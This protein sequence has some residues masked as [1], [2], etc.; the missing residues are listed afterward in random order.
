MGEWFKGGKWTPAPGS[1]PNGAGEE[2]V[3]LVDPSPVFWR[4]LYFPRVVSCITITARGATGRLCGIHVTQATEP[5]KAQRL[6]DRLKE[7]MD[8]VQ[9]TAIYVVGGLWLLGSGRASGWLGTFRS[10]GDL[11]DA[12]VTSLGASGAA[13]HC[14]GHPEGAQMDYLAA[15]GYG[16]VVWFHSPAGRGVWTKFHP[17]PCPSG[18]RRR[19]FR[20]RF[21]S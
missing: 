4:E 20:G 3:G 5:V 21:R 19:W 12:V 10:A 13:R 6:L 7:R 1:G 9:I 2:Q 14:H 17:G 16:Q 15:T 11:S 8:K 18:S